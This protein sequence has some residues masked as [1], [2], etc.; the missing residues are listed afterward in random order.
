MHRTKLRRIG[1]SLGLTLPRDALRRLGLG[2]GDALFLIETPEGLL[3]SPFDPTFAAALE[4]FEAT[5]GRFRNAL[6]ALARGEA[7]EDPE[8]WE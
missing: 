3:L 8:A 4:A 6:R 7:R 2:E 1:N 5:R